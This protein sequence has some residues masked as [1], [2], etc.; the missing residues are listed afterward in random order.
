MRTLAKL[1]LPILVLCLF[2]FT[3]RAQSSDA[4]V[5]NK[6]VATH[7]AKENGE[8]PEGVRKTITGD[9]NHDGVADTAVLYTIEGQ[10]KPTTMSNIWR[11]SCARTGV[12]C[13]RRG[14]QLGARVAVR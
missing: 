12:W 3:V 6:F 11:C 7:V 10:K 1:V 4:T 2:S 8:E 13:M 14:R 9:L 5:I